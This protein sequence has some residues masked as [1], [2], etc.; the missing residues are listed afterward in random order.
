MLDKVKRIIAL[1]LG[2]ER[3]YAT[4]SHEQEQKSIIFVKKISKTVNLIA[5][6]GAV[7]KNLKKGQVRV[8]PPS[9]PCTPIRPQKFLQIRWVTRKQGFKKIISEI[10][11]KGNGNQCK[12]ASVLRWP[13]DEQSSKEN[14]EAL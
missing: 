9:M 3:F 10:I 7:V 6:S 2:S 1:E 8:T 4:R 5:K 13:K 11:L 12:S 14:F